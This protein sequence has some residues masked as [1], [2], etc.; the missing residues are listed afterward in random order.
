MDNIHIRGYEYVN[1][2]VSAASLPSS[3]MLLPCFIASLLLQVYMD[4]SLGDRV[5]VDRADC[6][7][8]VENVQTAFGTRLPNVSMLASEIAVKPE[9]SCKLECL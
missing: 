1:E 8:F 6:R 7:A 3:E 4:D 2:E 5:W 9:S